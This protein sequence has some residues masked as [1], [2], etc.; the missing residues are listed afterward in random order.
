V[1]ELDS[2]AKTAFAALP[3]DKRKVLTSHDAFGYFGR[4][5]G[6]TFLS[7]VGLSTETEASASDVAKLIGQIKAEHVKV[8]FF[9][10]SNDPRLVRQIA[11]ATGAE[12]GGE[13]YVET[14]SP[15][16]GPASTYLKLFK[17][18]VDQVLAGLAK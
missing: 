5:Y 17:Y 7:P 9:E 12:P 10:N 15:P 8:Y 3:K 1:A 13:L 16:D 14:L 18:N 11:K 6:L 2:Y 4:E